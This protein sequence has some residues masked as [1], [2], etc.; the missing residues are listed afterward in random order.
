MLKGRW[1]ICSLNISGLN[2]PQKRAK[3]F[4]YLRKLNMDII[5]FQET[6]IKRQDSK[7]IKNKGLR[8]LFLSSDREKK[9]KGLVMFVKEKL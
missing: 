2:S 1:K 4:Q 5:C 9:K 8:K 7:L 3:A 6:H